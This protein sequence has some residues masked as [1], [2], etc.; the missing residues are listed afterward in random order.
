MESFGFL[1]PCY[2][3]FVDLHLALPLVKVVRSLPGADMNFTR[4]FYWC[5]FP[6]LF[7]ESCHCSRSVC[8]SFFARGPA[9]NQSSSFSQCF[10]VLSSSS[11]SSIA[12]FA[13]LIS[14]LCVWFLF[15]FLS[16]SDITFVRMR[17][18]HYPADAKTSKK[19]TSLSRI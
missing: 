2:F 5:F 18:S 13:E 11:A 7:F 6:F 12:P 16:K 4:G 3:R 15:F 8:R 14:L 1:D 9:S 19:G 17:S 10:E